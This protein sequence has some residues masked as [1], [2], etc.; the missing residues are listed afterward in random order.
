MTKYSIDIAAFDVITLLKFS[1]FL[2]FSL[3]AKKCVS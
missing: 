1:R 2:V 3:E